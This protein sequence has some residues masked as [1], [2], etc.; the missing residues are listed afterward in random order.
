MVY[1]AVCLQRR[2]YFDRRAAL[3]ES[4]A[5]CEPNV[6]GIF[7]HPVFVGRIFSSHRASFVQKPCKRRCEIKMVERRL[8]GGQPAFVGGGLDSAPNL[9]RAAGFQQLFFV[10][11]V[12]RRLRRRS[13]RFLPNQK[14]AR[15]RREHCVPGGFRFRQRF[16]FGKTASPENGPGHTRPGGQ[17]KAE[18]N[19]G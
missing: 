5:V 12:G 1:R 16:V 14:I 10:R 13:S 2:S 8:L 11:Y 15:N 7:T 17:I 3:F 9:S 18:P 6:S 19:P 4:A